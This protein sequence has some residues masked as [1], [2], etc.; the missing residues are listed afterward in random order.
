MHAAETIIMTEGNKTADRKI[1]RTILGT[2]R[3]E[4]HIHKYDELQN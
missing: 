3:T 2:V 1:L 4:K